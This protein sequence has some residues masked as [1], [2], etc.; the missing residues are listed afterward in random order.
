M[1][2]KILK[3]KLGKE[4]WKSLIELSTKI[5]QLKQLIKN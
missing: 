3:K 2:T 5:K 1:K 4:E